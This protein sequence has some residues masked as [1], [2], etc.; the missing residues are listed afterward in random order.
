MTEEHESAIEGNS[1]TVDLYVCASTCGTHEKQ[2]TIIQGVE[3]LTE[4]GLVDDFERYLWPG[5]V[6]TTDDDAWC[7]AAQETYDEFA[8]WARSEG[9]SL[10]P[11][12]TRRTVRNEFS[13]QEYEVIRFP[14]LTLAVR[15]DGDVARVAPSG[16]TERHY[17]V[18][19]CLD[20]LRT[21]EQ[22]EDR[23]PTLEP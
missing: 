9:R 22:P 14:V 19:D 4:A 6:T 5:R 18:E 13:D 1:L 2:R 12:F 3:A 23:P 20:E 15:A 11:A 21:F 10:G 7:T 17:S 8:S 16:E